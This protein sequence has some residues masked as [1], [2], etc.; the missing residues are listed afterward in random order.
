MDALENP[1]GGVVVRAVASG[2]T[3]TIGRVLAHTDL[4]D[5]DEVRHRVL[6]RADCHARKL[7]S[8]GVLVWNDSRVEIFF[9]CT[10]SN[11]AAFIDM[12]PF[13]LLHPIA[14]KMAGRSTRSIGQFHATVSLR[15]SPSVPD[16]CRGI[17]FHS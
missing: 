2:A 3:V 10:N 11:I 8:R 5:H 12:K 4:G 9:I 6:D 1:G 7:Q 17:F 14:R 15:S 16:F 13:S